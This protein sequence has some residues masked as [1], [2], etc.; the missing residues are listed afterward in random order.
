VQHGPALRAGEAAGDV[1]DLTTQRGA[2]SDRVA[3]ASE[4]A[5]CAQQVVGDGSADRPGGVR[6]EDP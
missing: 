4:A 2:A 5:G 3:A 1:D 6:R